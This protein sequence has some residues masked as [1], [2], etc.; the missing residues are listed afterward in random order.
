MNKTITI[1][2]IHKIQ[3]TGEEG[4]FIAIKIGRSSPCFTS[5]RIQEMV[6]CEP[7]EVIEEGRGNILSLSVK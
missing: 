5:W 3:E 7:S 6:I 2:K 4:D 1:T